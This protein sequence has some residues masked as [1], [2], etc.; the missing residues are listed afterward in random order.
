MDRRSWLKKIGG[1]VSAFTVVK[2]VSSCSSDEAEADC[3]AAA[4]L[5]MNNADITKIIKYYTDSP[6]TYISSNQQP[7]SGLSYGTKVYANLHKLGAED[8]AVEASAYT[9]KTLAVIRG[10]YLDT[11]D[12]GHNPTIASITDVGDSMEIKFSVNHGLQPA[13]STSHGITAFDLW[14]KDASNSDEPTLI[15]SIEIGS[16]EGKNTEKTFTITKTQAGENLNYVMV[17]H[18][19]NHGGRIFIGDLKATA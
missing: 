4:P 12:S 14:V 13:T 1:A 6:P 15:Q 3:P 2:L 9:T 19:N 7:A 5:A 10:A 11:A 8:A 17:G 18:C 16:A